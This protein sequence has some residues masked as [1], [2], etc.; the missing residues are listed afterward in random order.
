[1]D[2]KDVRFIQ[3]IMFQN[4]KISINLGKC[5]VEDFCSMIKELI[6]L[7]G[8]DNIGIGSDLCLNWPDEI[9]MWMRNGKWTKKIDYGESKDNNPKWKFNSIEKVSQ[10]WINEHTKSAWE[11]NPLEDL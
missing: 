10:D 6:N 4:P 11:T 3:L 7:I 1:M 9:V 8:E 5:K 2:Q